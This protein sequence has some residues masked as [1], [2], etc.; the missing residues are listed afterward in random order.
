MSI[1]QSFRA[2][3]PLQPD[4]ALIAAVAAWHQEEDFTE[5]AGDD[6]EVARFQAE[7]MRLHRLIKATPA[8]TLKGAVAKGS[9]AIRCDKQFN[10]D[11]H[12]QFEELAM[13]ALRELLALQPAPVVKERRRA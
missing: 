4:A 9:V 2:A 5:S 7:A 3:A 12:D 1:H 10:G 11:A 13:D 8:V 6:S